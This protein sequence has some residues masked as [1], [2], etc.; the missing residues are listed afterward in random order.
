M[1]KQNNRALLKQD[2]YLDVDS[3]LFECYGHQM[4][5]KTT[6]CTYWESRSGFRHNVIFTAW[7]IFIFL[8]IFVHV[9]PRERKKGSFVKGSLRGV[10]Q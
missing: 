3:T 2:V 10:R 8:T 7:K 4:D 6:L 5:V 9:I 1:L